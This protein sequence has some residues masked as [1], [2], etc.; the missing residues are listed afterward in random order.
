MTNIESH[1]PH[2][3]FYF[4]LIESLLAHSK[5]FIDWLSGKESMFLKLLIVII[6]VLYKL[7]SNFVII[8]V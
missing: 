7:E 2:F 5:I 8:F 4:I 3:R 1:F 6:C